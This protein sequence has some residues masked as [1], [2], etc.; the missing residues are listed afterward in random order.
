MTASAQGLDVSNYQGQFS[1]AAA[2]KTIPDLQ[3]GVYRLTQGLGGSGTGSPDPQAAWNH[4]QILDQ[5]LARGMYHFLD[6]SLGGQQQARYFTDEADRLGLAGDDMLWLDNETQ[7][8]SP[9]AVAACAQEFM[10]ELTRLAP[11]NPRGV[12]SYISFIVYGNC[13][14]LG[15]YPLWLAYPAAT[16]PKPPPEWTKWTFWQWGLRNGTD[17]DAFNG[18]AAQLHGWLSSYSPGTPS[19]APVP[20]PPPGI[21]LPELLQ[22]SSG[23]AVSAVQAL[24]GMRGHPVAADG[25]FGPATAAAVRDVQSAAKISVDGIVGPQTWVALV[26]L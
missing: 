21:T 25:I 6:P 14:G 24:C 13:A 3:F 4:A 1:W 7:G 9:Q 10:T 2:K 26:G 19:P 11:H 5:G 20:S 23:P 17:A 12:Y 8:S 18:T 15:G 16:A 22:G